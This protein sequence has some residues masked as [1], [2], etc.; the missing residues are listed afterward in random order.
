MYC[1]K[2]GVNKPNGPFE[3]NN[4]ERDG[5]QVETK[6]TAEASGHPNTDASSSN[7]ITL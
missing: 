3:M 5:V 7:T 4:L 6:S 1:D 2:C